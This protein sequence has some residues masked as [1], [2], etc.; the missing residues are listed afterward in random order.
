MIM[1]VGLRLSRKKGFD[2]QAWSREV[3]GLDAVNVAR[4][5]LFGNP[6]SVLPQHPPGKEF[7]IIGLART[8]AVPTAEDAVACFDEMLDQPGETADKLR[9]ALH[10]LRRKNLACWCRLEDACHRN[11][12]L[13]RANA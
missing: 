1:P 7:G 5:H 13:R 2:L 9:A 6:F 4:P 3:N 8:I 10:T 11:V 12:L